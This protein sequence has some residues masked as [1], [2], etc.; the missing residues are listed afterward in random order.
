MIVTKLWHD[1]RISTQSIYMDYRKCRLH[2]NRY[3]SIYSGLRRVQ[4]SLQHLGITLYLNND[5]SIDAAIW[6]NS[7]GTDSSKAGGKS[8]KPVEVHNVY[9]LVGRIIEY[10]LEHNLR[11]FSSTV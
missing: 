2:E 10:L 7:L 8:C 4:N 1:R 9:A 5:A 11:Y 3:Y 6:T